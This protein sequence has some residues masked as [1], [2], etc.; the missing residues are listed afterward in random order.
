MLNGPWLK[1]VD[2]DRS[3]GCREVHAAAG[4][5]KMRLHDGEL[6]SRERVNSGNEK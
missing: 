6:E 2:E 4:C 3:A 5:E 1:R